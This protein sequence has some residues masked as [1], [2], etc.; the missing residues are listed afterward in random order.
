ME[1]ETPVIKVGGGLSREGSVTWTIKDPITQLLV[2]REALKST[3]FL[4]DLTVTVSAQGA[5]SLSRAMA[6]FLVL[7]CSTLCI[8]KR[9]AN[10]QVS[11]IRLT[12]SERGEK[13]LFQ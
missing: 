11:M 12:P 8:E 5:I 9:Y 3:G 10:I 7:A 2:L 13:S 1:G 6:L 4:H